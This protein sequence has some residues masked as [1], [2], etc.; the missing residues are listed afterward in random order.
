MT[1]PKHFFGAFRDHDS[2]YRTSSVL[3]WM[4]Y[5]AH[6]ED[7]GE[8]ENDWNALADAAEDFVKGRNQENGLR[9]SRYD[10]VFSSDGTVMHV[11]YGPDG[12][13]ERWDERTGNFPLTQSVPSHRPTRGRKRYDSR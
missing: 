9:V 1:Y 2:I 6:V 8:V 11:L 7:H 13:V 10:T 3:A 4:V 5:H 12:S